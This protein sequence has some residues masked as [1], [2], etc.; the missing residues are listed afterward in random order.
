VLA[1]VMLAAVLLM[2]RHDG[3][4]QTPVQDDTGAATA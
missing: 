2:P 1:V 4:V 3:P